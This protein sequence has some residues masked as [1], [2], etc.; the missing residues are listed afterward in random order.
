[1]AAADL[2]PVP[3]AD[4]ASVRAVLGD[5]VRFT[6]VGALELGQRRPLVPL[7]STPEAHPA[8]RAALEPV[9]AASAVRRHEAEL[10]RRAEALLRAAATDDGP[11][12]L[13][14]SLSR[15]LPFEALIVLLGTDD[16][17]APLAELH[18]GILGP[19]ADPA[20]RQAVGDRIWGHF[21]PLVASRRHGIGEDLIATLQRARLDGAPLDEDDITATCYLLLLAGIDPVAG[22][23][24]AWF[25]HLAPLGP[26]RRDLLDDASAVR[27]TI[28]ELLRWSATVH[29]LTR[30]ATVAT[31]V[32]GRPV[33][34][35]QRVACLLAA[36]NRDP[37][38]FADP[39]RFDPERA[40]A[41]HVAF[42]WGA[43]R[44]IGAHL[45]R[46]ELRIAAEAAEVVFPGYRPDPD[47]PLP[48]PDRASPREPLRIVAR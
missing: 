37:A 38:A 29:Q 44:C 17:V 14:A 33:A 19:D 4:H 27:R 43:H 31:E 24:A 39:E 1:V 21:A 42:G 25:A 9:F 40:A 26:A 36:A 15:R 10:R 47:H 30:V 12:D 7:Q 5:A 46:L 16:E 35:G 23:L 22:G 32:A 28:E 41:S 2:D 6:A 34:A 48:S 13:N 20:D 18:D 45:A 8:L 11:I 3:A